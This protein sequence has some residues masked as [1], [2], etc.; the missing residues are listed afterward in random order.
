MKD[1]IHDYDYLAHLFTLSRGYMTSRIFLTALEIGVFQLIGTQQL[2]ASQIAQQLNTDERATEILLNA[3]TGMGLM[4][5]NCNL[6]INVKE[7]AD[8]L[9][10]GS[11][12]YQGGVFSHINHLWEGWSHLTEIVRSGQS[13]NKEWTDAMRLDLAMAMK[14]HAIGKTDKIARF[15]DCSGAKHM[16][17]LGGGPGSYAIAFAQCYPHLNVVIFD[18]D[19][20]TLRIASEEIA[21]QD[22]K[23]RI[24]LKKGD[25]L[26]D[27][28]G[29][30]YDLIL[31]SS[32]ICLLG[33]KENIGLLKKAKESL[34]PGGKLVVWDL[35]LDE[36]KTRPISA[37]I[38]SVNML[39]TTRTGR[40][41]SF[42]EVRGW[43]HSLGLKDI[44]LI[45]VNSFHL[46]MGKNE[47]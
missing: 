47:S 36:S 3:L 7:V 9:R 8:L 2:T 4:R 17:D 11:P 35:I 6:F 31:L 14:E 38:F 34:N 27:D 15:V 29:R 33:E 44:H 25:F 46:I 18:R 1:P 16:L 37:A 13:G 21:R 30:G 22:L 19:D 23:D 45:P 5:K 43:F 41:Y 26:V 40:S 10:P 32:I 39:V 28:I 12:H 24:H 20:Q 42:S